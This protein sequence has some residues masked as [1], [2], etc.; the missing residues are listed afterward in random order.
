MKLLTVVA[1]IIAALCLT[2]VRAQQ[3]PTQQ[4]QQ[5][6]IHINNLGDASYEV[7][8]KMTQMQWENFKQ[9]PLVNDPS[10]TRRDMQRGMSAY[11][12]EDF[13][14]DIDEMNRTVKM[15]FKVKAISSY[16]G[17][18]KWEMKLDSKDAQITKLSDKSF[19]ITSN[20]VFNGQLTQQVFKVFFP[21]TASNI[22]QT[23]D[24]FNKTIFTY[25]DGGG[26]LSIFV[27]NNV[28]GI[29]LI[30]AAG[31]SFLRNYGK[32]DITALSKIMVHPPT[33]NT[34]TEKV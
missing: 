15:D 1:T 10:I 2:T 25:K 18:G 13:K 7:S 21:G 22:Q 32:T 12:I 29:L 11:V 3:D 26:I 30:L 19:M 23:T 28:V 5:F 16:K 20:A 27:W 33:V 17:D 6:D 31:A 9:G 24:S 8:E 14:R 34:S 4:V